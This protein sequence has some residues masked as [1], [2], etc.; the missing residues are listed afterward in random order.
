MIHHV[1]RAAVAAA[2]FITE[3]SSQSTG[4]STESREKSEHSQRE[5]RADA[6]TRV[7]AQPSGETKPANR[8]MSPMERARMFLEKHPEIRARLFAKADTDH[9]G[10]LSTAERE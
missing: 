1:L 9:D 3:A 10:K 5:P 6:Q 2:L 4:R 7:G 8:E